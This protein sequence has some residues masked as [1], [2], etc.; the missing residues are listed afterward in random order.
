MMSVFSWFARRLGQR[1]LVGLLGA[2][3]A[4]CIGGLWV[5]SASGYILQGPH[6]LALMAESLSGAKTLRVEQQVTI[7]DPAIA[8]EPVILNE[9]LS[10]IFPGQFRSEIVHENTRR[11]QVV[12]DGQTLTV[13]DNKIV[14][15]PEGRFD[16]YRDLLLYN[17]PNLLHKTLSIQGVDVGISSLGRLGDKVVYVIGAHY[18]DESVSQVWV[19]REKFVPL[20]WVTVRAGGDPTQNV[21]RWEFIYAGWQKVDGLFY[22]FRIE[23]FHN[24]R[25]IRRIRVTKVDANATIDP[26]SVNI[27]HLQTVYQMQ[28]APMPSDGQSSSE[29][30]EVQRTIEAFKKKFEP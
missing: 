1:V 23:T 24:G 4:G 29:I 28:E 13:V 30:D 25:R 16:R 17:S 22:P 27:A 3:V 9:T 5:G 2:T 14:R 21:D 26:S 6:L 10:F 18:P 8:S 20:R 12:S 7:E 11:I 15:N 19:D